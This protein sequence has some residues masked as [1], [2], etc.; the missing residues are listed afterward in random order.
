MPSL[1]LS[2]QSI[3]QA[4]R[5]MYDEG[6]TSDLAGRR[7]RPTAWWMYGGEDAYYNDQWDEWQRDGYPSREDA[8]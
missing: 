1:S 4:L 6:V 2:L 7:S 3:R 8:D 5:A